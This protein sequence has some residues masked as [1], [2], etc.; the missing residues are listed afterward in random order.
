[1][2][3]NDNYMTWDD[4]NGDSAHISNDCSGKMWKHAHHSVAGDVKAK[5]I[6]RNIN[7]I[8]IN[9]TIVI[10]LVIKSNLHE[11]GGHRYDARVP[12]ATAEVSRHDNKN[13]RTFEHGPNLVY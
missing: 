7:N 4:E 6:L 9:I 11:G 2:I 12:P 8:I 1:M 5:N 13:R 10:N 3:N